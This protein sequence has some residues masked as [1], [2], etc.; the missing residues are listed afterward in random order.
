MRPLAEQ[1]ILITGVTNGLGLALAQALASKGATVLLHGR[2]GKRGL[3]VLDE[4]KRRT[5]NDKLKFYQADLASLRQTSELARQIVTEHRRL[6]VLVNNAAVGFG[7]EGAQRETSQ[8]GY[9]LRFA[10]NYL[11]PYL[12]VEGLLPL[13]KDSTPAR[14]VN[15]ASVGQAPLDFKDIMFEHAYLGVTAYRRSKLAMIAWTFDLAARLAN[16]EVTANALHPASLMPTK[17]VLESGWNVMSTVEEGLEATIRL[18][19]DPALDGVTGKYFDGLR[20]AKANA[21]AY[22]LE[23]R[24]QLAVLTRD[25]VAT[26][27]RRTA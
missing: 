23:V 9:E 22:D 16:T 17:M 13:L 24:S 25:L 19:I 14:I 3:A 6:D 11:A 2:D 8:D 7:K 21:Q 26:A 10:V 20:E 27:L 1:T 4:I 18:V 5:G 12:L 15:V